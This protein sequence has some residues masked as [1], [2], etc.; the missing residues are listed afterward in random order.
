[1]YWDASIETLKPQKLRELQLR[2]LRETVARAALSPFYGERLA[3][4][5]VTAEKIGS[6]EDV[7]KIPFTLKD[8]LRARGR[9]M[10]TVSLAEIVRLHASSGTTGQATVI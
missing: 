5:G 7:R 4:A 3:Q 1:M 9:E 2:R 10:L 6:L 8:D